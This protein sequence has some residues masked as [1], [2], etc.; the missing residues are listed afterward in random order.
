M[1]G[2]AIQQNEDGIIIGQ[3]P[4]DVRE[5]LWM[6]M[7]DL[8]AEVLPLRPSRCLIRLSAQVSSL[9]RG[10]STRIT[11]ICI[12][13]TCLLVSAHGR[14]FCHEIRRSAIIQ[15]SLHGRKSIWCWQGNVSGRSA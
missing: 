7:T 14:Y 2:V 15:T 6:Q 8:R 10:D 5:E 4:L 9:E 13:Q 1:E 12:D 3:D 11:L